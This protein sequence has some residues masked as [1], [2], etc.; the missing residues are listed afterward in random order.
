MRAALAESAGAPAGQPNP[1]RQPFLDAMSLTA[2]TV[3]VVT[4]DGPAG[5]AGM[6]VSAMTPVSAD[7]DAPT[8][9]ICINGNSRAVRPLLMNRVFCVNVL[10][11][12]QAMVADAFAGRLAQFGGNKF[13]CGQWR[14]TAS[15]A[16]RLDGA[17][18]SMECDL[19]G[20][21]RHATH[22]VIFGAVRGVAPG[23]PGKPL[24]HFN[25]GYMGLVD[26][27]A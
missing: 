15:G 3:T 19:A 8:L 24:V 18:V 6:T 2:A 25:R 4:T 27:E 12:D 20:H 11:D 16:P 21:Q 22:H 17:L 14:E 26:R 10:R 13:A 23:A 5:R 1:L 9:L 7:G